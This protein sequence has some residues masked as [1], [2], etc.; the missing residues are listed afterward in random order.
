[1]NKAGQVFE[2]NEHLVPIHHYAAVD[3]VSS[4]IDT[5]V[6]SAKA[7]KPSIMQFSSHKED[8]KPLLCTRTSTPSK[9]KFLDPAN[10][11]QNGFNANE[12]RQAF[13]R[14]FVTMLVDYQQYIIGN[15]KENE[16]TAERKPSYFS[17][18]F[19]VR[20][21]KA[22]NSSSHHSVYSSTVFNGEEY[23]QTHDDLFLRRLYVY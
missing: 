21:S 8:V 12:I 4:K 2:D 18:H 3:G 17:S 6:N 23:L 10:N 11:V 13:L 16:E 14:F 15:K 22:L 1:M 20:N 5:A 7:A 19:S 9:D